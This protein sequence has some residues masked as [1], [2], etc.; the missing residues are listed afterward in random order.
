[1]VDKKLTRAQPFAQL[2]GSGA[3]GVRQINDLVSAGGAFYRRSFFLPELRAAN[4]RAEGQHDILGR[5]VK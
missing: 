5:N 4:V 1:M 3:V 2:S